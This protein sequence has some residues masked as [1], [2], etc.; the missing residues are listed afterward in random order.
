MGQARLSRVKLS[1]SSSQYV[2]PHLARAVLAPRR[3]FD[4]DRDEDVTGRVGFN[5]LHHAPRRAENVVG[6]EEEEDAAGAHVL[7]KRVQAFQ[8]LRDRGTRHMK[9]RTRQTRGC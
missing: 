7:G 9:R 1:S 6:E 5:Q 8:A 4:E 2:F 3:A